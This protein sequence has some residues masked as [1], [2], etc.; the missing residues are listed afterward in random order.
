[1]SNPIRFNRKLV[2]MKKKKKKKKISPVSN[3]RILGFYFFLRQIRFSFSKEHFVLFFRK[4]VLTANPRFILESTDWMVLQLLKI[5]IAK[6]F[7]KN[8]LYGL[9][10]WSLISSGLFLRSNMFALVSFFNQVKSNLFYASTCLIHNWFLPS[11]S[12]LILFLSNSSRVASIV[13][14]FKYYLVLIIT[15]FP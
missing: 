3:C 14:L 11:A 5:C 1:M 7:L 4:T 8:G 9:V 12:V 10:I 15:Y 6:S 13:I 2:I